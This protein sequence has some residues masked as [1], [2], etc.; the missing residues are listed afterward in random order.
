[1]KGRIQILPS[2]QIDASRWDR[3]IN[4]NTHGLIYSRKKNLDL[5]CDQWQGLVVD[6]YKLIMPIPW[7]K[8]FGIRYAYIPPFCQQLGIIGT[9]GDAQMRAIYEALHG[10]AKYGDIHFNYNNVHV[11]D[12][13]TVTAK[14]NFIIDLSKDIYAIRSAYRN[15]LKEN[16]RKAAAENLQYE[17]ADLNTAIDNFMQQY[18]KRIRSIGKDD[19][20]R[21]RK[22]CETLHQEGN[23]L[24]RKAASQG[25]ET[26]AI[27]LFLKD[28][29]RIYNI[30][31]TTLPAGKKKSANHFLL[32]Q[33]LAEFAG[34]SLLF[35]MEGSELPGVR[36]FY[37][38]FSPANQPYYHYHFN[39]LPWPLYLLKR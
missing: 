11:A 8:K 3:C 13:C 4:S 18:G 7:R 12:H 21:L 5:L 32:D 15:D 9:D 19:F 2:A 25:G 20:M 34:S 14:N 37:E 10:F 24:V 6:D 26:L 30:L 27:A 31:N 17:V 36:H 29:K 16:I 22:V 23:C 33:L 39:K 1:M 35:D 38:G 28:Q